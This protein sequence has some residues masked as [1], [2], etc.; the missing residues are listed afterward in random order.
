MIDTPYQC[1]ICQQWYVRVE[2]VSCCVSHGP[3]QCCHY[4]ERLATL[5]EV[6]EVLLAL[7]ESLAKWGSRFLDWADSRSIMRRKPEDD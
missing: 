1:S 2:N 6:D 7:R 3:G 5:D 4:G